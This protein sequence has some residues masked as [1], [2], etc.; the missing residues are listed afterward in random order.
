MTSGAD[1]C[2]EVERR[3]E[4]SYDDNSLSIFL[5]YFSIQVLA[6]SKLF[7]S[8]FKSGIPIEAKGQRPR[9][10]CLLSPS[11]RKTFTEILQKPP[12]LSKNS[13]QVHI[14]HSNQNRAWAEFYW[15]SFLATP[16]CQHL[17]WM[18]SLMLCDS[19]ACHCKDGYVGDTNNKCIPYWQCLKDNQEKMY[20]R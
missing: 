4:G 7:T 16:L 1:I 5:L 11:N 10:Q 20:G 2:I 12:S 6:T 9:P 8:T 17:Y 13:V 3:K 19:K 18:K 14:D 15:S